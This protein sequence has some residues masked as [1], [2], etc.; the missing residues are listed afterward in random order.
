MALPVLTLHLA[1]TKLGAY[2]ARKIPES[3]RDQVR[4][5]LEFA[6]NHVTLIESRPH[7]REPG[8]WSRLPVARFRFNPGAGTWALLSPVFANKEAWRLYPIQP[9]RDLDKLI[10]TVDEDAN[11][12][13]WG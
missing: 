10:A 3:A 2:C 4:L 1:R 13:F 11:G 6:D 5:E 7:F 9:S 12:V 8:L